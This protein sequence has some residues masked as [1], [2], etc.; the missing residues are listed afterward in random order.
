MSARYTHAHH[1]LDQ[2]AGESRHEAHEHGRADAQSDRPAVGEVARRVVPGFF[3]VPRAGPAAF[4][5][6][7]GWLLLVL[8][9][10]PPAAALITLVLVLAVAGVLLAAVATL[11][12]AP[13]LLAHYLITHEPIHRHWFAFLHRHARRATRYVPVIHAKGTP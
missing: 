4:L 5:L 12:A 9:I 10:I 7:G 2:A 3:F 11:I 8:L 1:V 13:Y 6:L